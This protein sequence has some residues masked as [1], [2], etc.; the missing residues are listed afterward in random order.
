V[1]NYVAGNEVVITCNQ[2]TRYKVGVGGTVATETD[3]LIAAD[4][5]IRYTFQGVETSVA[6]QATTAASSC[7]VG[8]NARTRINLITKDSIPELDPDCDENDADAERA[9]QCRNLRGSEFDLIG[10][11]KQ[12][13]PARPRWVVIPRAAD[14]VCCYPGPGL[15]CPK[16]I[17][18]CV[19]Q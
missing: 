13:Q 10:H 15:E 11:L 2:P 7:S 1:N 14:D 17:Q 9:Q 8:L 6:F 4:Q 5:M 16:P 18:R 12:V 19:T 3:P